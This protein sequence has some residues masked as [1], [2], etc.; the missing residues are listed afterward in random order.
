MYFGLKFEIVQIT[1]YLDV[2]WV[3]SAGGIDI[4]S[5][6]PRSIVPLYIISSL[7]IPIYVGAS[8][9]CIMLNSYFLLKYF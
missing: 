8:V 9:C 2:S 1:F 7:G 3:L 4:P 5:R 6:A